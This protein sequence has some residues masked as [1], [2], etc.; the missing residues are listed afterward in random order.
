MENIQV[1]LRIRPQNKQEITSGDEAIWKTR[2]NQVG[3]EVFSN[4]N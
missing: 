2:G 1:A 4:E 3:L